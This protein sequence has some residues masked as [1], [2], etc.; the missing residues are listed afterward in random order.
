[1]RELAPRQR[2]CLAFIGNYFLRERFPPSVRE[3]RIHMGLSS[4]NGVSDHL[5]A[6]ERKG[7]VERPI[8]HASRALRLTG[9][10]WSE[11]GVFDGQ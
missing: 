11:L 8:K 1:M 10:G 2:A 3:I 4:S 5:A 7:F 9:A 6:L